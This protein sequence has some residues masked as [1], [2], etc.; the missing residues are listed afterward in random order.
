MYFNKKC[1]I[2]HYKLYLTDSVLR[3]SVESLLSLSAPILCLQVQF[4]KYTV[5]LRFA[6]TSAYLM[7]LSTLCFHKQK[8]FINP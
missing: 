5:L 7:Q 8:H 1:L 3:N 6:T 4:F 2:W